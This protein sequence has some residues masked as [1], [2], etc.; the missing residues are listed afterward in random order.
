M[1]PPGYAV[2]GTVTDWKDVPVAGATLSLTGLGKTHEAKTDSEGHYR[3]VSVPRGTYRYRVDARGFPPLMGEFA[4]AKPPDGPVDIKLQVL[5]SE[6]INVKAD[7]GQAGGQFGSLTLSAED[8]QGIPAGQ[9]Y[10]RLR[11]L[12]GATGRPETIP[13]HVDGFRAG[14]RLPPVE[15]IEMVRISTNSFAAEFPEIGY[16]RIEITTK[17]GVDTY[18]AQLQFD[19]TDSALNARDPFAPS[20]PSS[21]VR[22]YNGYVGGPIVRNRWD[23]LAYAGN[24]EQNTS[25]VVNATVLNPVSLDVEPLNVNFPT[26]SR[27]SNVFLQS[28]YRISATNSLSASYN[29]T[30][31]RGRNLGLESGRALPEYGFNRSMQDGTT[32]VAL[33]S[34][35][36]ARTLNELRLERVVRTRESQAA[37]ARPAIVVFDAFS[38]GGNQASFFTRDVRDSLQVMNHLTRAHATHTAKIGLEM[39]VDRLDTL[40]RSGWGGTFVFGSD[41]E[42]DATG[43]PIVESGQMRLIS[44][45]QN[46]RQTLMGAPGYG[47]SQF[48]IVTGTPGIDVSQWEMALFAQDDWRP[49]PTLTVSYGLRTEWQTNLGGALSAA[50]RAGLA[51][52]PDANGRSTVRMAGGLFYNRV[53]PSLTLEALKLDGQHQRELIVSR[54]EFFPSIPESLA[55][56]TVVSSIRRRDDAL[57]PPFSAVTSF[58]YERQLPSKVLGSVEYRGQSGWRQLRSRRLPGAADGTPPVL[59]FES[60]GR[61]SRHEFVAGARTYVR[62]QLVFVSYTLSFSRNDTDGA[63]SLPADSSDVANEFGWAGADQRHKLTISGGTRLPLGLSLASFVT[64][65][66]G[67]PFNITTGRDNNGDTVFTDRPSL[68]SPADPEA[69]LTPF[70]WLNSNPQPGQRIVAR[71]LGRGAGEINASLYML[72]AFTLSPP[73]TTMAADT[74]GARSYSLVVSASAENVINR[75]NL[76]GYNTVLISSAFGQPN[77]AMAPRVVKVSVSLSF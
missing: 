44:P 19:L 17:P 2:E 68:S 15:A 70:G 28:G 42:R 51:W 55:A 57:A 30:T 32:R 77:A 49:S 21:Q 41:V 52:T 6:S 66:S 12:A 48:S 50:P 3:F 69:M 45:I 26:P 29:R 38:A 11:E 4:L 1:T 47:P 53:D 24:W 62:E 18:H 56:T 20:R 35:I 5:V 73:P 14:L 75:T 27:T 71:N 37:T 10:Q 7:G 40:D 63:S 65:G 59:Q 58:S 61:S 39:K 46:Y 54:P 25:Q 72:R 31:D 67:K 22:N 43:A 60:T 64:F 34:T 33:I 74:T 36:G 16:G 23:F 76:T 9:L 8:L 13:I